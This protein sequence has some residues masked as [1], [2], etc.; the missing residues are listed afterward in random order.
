MSAVPKALDSGRSTPDDSSMFARCVSLILIAAI[1]VCPL[2][3]GN[4]QCHADECCLATQPSDQ[5]CPAHVTAHCCCQD[6]CPDND[7]RVPRRCPS[8]TSCQ[9]VCGGAV[10]EKLIE[11]DD[12]S[13]SSF[14][15]G[16]DTDTPLL[17]RLIEYS[18]THRA[19]R[20]WHS[21]G[22]NNGRSLRTLHM[23]L[24]V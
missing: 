23:S 19:E 1:V 6:S 20:H 4:G 24:L 2:R 16:I 17:T 11:L 8:E 3:C 18:T 7:D 14:P 9:G 10:F 15:P 13:D 5:V 22:G 12:A 21:H